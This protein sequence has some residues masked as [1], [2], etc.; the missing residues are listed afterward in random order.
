MARH[1]TYGDSRLA[2][3]G[4]STDV[5]A[6][7]VWGSRA[8]RLQISWD[9]RFPELSLASSASRNAGGECESPSMREAVLGKQAMR[10]GDLQH[11]RRT[12]SVIANIACNAPP[13][14]ANCGFG[15]K[16]SGS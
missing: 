16:V 10:H 2:D 14:F 3:I 6:A 9:T 7:D 8:R 11:P 4:T 13:G 5:V 1:A 15:T 12:R